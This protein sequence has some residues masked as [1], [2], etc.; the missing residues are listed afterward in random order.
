MWEWCIDQ[1]FLILASAG[2]GQEH[3]P[4]WFTLREKPLPYPSIMRG[5]GQS[6]SGL[7]QEWRR[8][9]SWPFH[10]PNCNLS[11]IQPTASC[12]TNY[13]TPAP[14]SI[15]TVVSWPPWLYFTNHYHTETSVPSHSPLTPGVTSLKAGNLAMLLKETGILPSHASSRGNHLQWPPMGLVFT[16][17]FSTLM[18]LSHCSL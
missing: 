17:D 5:R 2:G 3:S 15:N 10:N 18:G 14:P 16:L 11:I 6:R 12:Y 13:A 4:C 1:H 7:L 8:E 9:N